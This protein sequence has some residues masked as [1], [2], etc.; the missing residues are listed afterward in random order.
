M[1]SGSKLSFHG[2]TGAIFA[3]LRR[4]AARH[5]IPVVQ[6]AGE[7]E[8]D[9]VRIRWRYDAGAGL[10]QVECVRAPFW[11]DASSINRK[12][13]QEIEAALGSDRAA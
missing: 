13:S 3:R 5:G 10:L 9:G 6:P 11:V 12:L 2:I 1:L 4:R 7:A 8:K